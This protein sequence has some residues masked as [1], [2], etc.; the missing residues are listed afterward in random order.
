MSALHKPELGEVLDPQEC[1]AC[2]YVT[3]CKVYQMQGRRNFHNGERLLAPMCYL[4]AST[5]TGTA[6]QYPEQYPEQRTLQ[7]ACFVGNLLL[8]G[9][10]EG[11]AQALIELVQER[12][13][14]DLDWGD[15][16]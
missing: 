4:C 10:G 8:D 7:V 14:P 5:A 12:E 9:L 2:G 6:Y 16:E 1:F 13:P 3:R 11:K 15:I